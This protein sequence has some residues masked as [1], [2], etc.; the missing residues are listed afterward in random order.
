MND[1]TARL[2]ALLRRIHSTALNQA[3]W[4]T[5]SAEQFRGDLHSLV[6]EYGPAAVNAAL[7]KIPDAASP[8]DS[9]H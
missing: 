8:S 9:M 3:E 6:S 5:A 2:E 1:L 7:D 4:D